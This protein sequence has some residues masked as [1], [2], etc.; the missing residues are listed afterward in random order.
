MDK[1]KAIV[2]TILFAII[3]IGVTTAMIFIK[4]HG[5]EISLLHVFSPF[6]VGLWIGDIIEKFYKWISK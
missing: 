1:K 2:C 3:I 5:S 4:P 6:F